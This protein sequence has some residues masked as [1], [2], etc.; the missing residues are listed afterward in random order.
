MFAVIAMLPEHVGVSP[1]A[2]SVD[3]ASRFG[4]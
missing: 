1:E 2:G 3:V 4:G